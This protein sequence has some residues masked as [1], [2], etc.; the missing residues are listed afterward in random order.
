MIVWGKCSESLPFSASLL[1]M[2][3]HQQLSTP[4]HFNSLAL[5][6]SALITKAANSAYS[7]RHSASLTGSM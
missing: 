7:S 6:L 1:L 3:L 4:T 5:T 2:L